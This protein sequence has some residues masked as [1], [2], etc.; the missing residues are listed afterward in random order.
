M[1]RKIRMIEGRKTLLAHR[2]SYNLIRGPIPDGLYI[3]HFCDR[4]VCVN[5]FHLFTG[6]MRENFLD[7]KLKFNP[8][9]KYSVERNE[10]GQVI[11]VIFLEPLN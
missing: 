10:Q 5:P 7:Y 9:P 4:P 11:K 2:V 1:Y 3:C 8:T 6:T